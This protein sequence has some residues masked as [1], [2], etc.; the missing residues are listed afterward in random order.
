MKKY[1]VASAISGILL[2][3]DPEPTD[4]VKTS[5]VPMRSLSDSELIPLRHL[6]YRQSLHFLL[7]LRTRFWERQVTRPVPTPRNENKHSGGKK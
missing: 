1:I 6:Q 5:R 7:H 3:S 2:A 4:Y